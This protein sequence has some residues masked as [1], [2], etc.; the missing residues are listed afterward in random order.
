MNLSK[1]EF[2]EALA[3]LGFKRA[4]VS[5][6]TQLWRV[7]TLTDPQLPQIICGISLVPGY[8]YTINVVRT[9]GDGWVCSSELQSYVYAGTASD[10]P[11]DSGF[12]DALKIVS[13]QAALHDARKL[14]IAEGRAAK[15]DAKK[16]Q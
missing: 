9:P 4:T 3:E 13:Q 8:D 10:N 2:E 16:K 12:T 1:E 15:V 7:E 5:Q 14:D 11:R 6:Y